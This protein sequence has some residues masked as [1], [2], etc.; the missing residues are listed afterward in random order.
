MLK[1]REI[2]DFGADRTVFRIGDDESLPTRDKLARLVAVAS[3]LLAENDLPGAYEILSEDEIV[4]AVPASTRH[5]LHDG[6]LFAA[7][8][9]VNDPVRNPTLTRLTEEE[10]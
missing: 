4:L 1:V 2:R 10:P 5:F 7:L 8:D 9:A 3:R 6:I